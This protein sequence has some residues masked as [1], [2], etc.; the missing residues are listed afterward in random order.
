MNFKAWKLKSWISWLSRF[1]MTCTK[2]VPLN[3]NALNRP[4][5]HLSHKF[6]NWN[7]GYWYISQTNTFIKLSMFL[8]KTSSDRW[9]LIFEEGFN[10]KC[11]AVSFSWYDIVNSP[12][13]KLKALTKCS[14]RMFFSPYCRCLVPSRELFKTLFLSFLTLCWGHSENCFGINFIL[15]SIITLICKLSFFYGYARDSSYILYV[16]VCVIYI[17]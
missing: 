2:H 4:L 12:W 10:S 9:F 13:S 6:I 16:T 14:Q 17:V 15:Q 3:E 11:S 7:A 5:S 1:Y 8:S